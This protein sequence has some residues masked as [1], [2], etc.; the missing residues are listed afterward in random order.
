MAAPWRA[1]EPVPPHGDAQL[2]RLEAKQPPIAIIDAPPSGGPGRA[3]FEAF[4]AGRRG[5]G[6]TL[7]ATA[8]PALLGL[9]DRVLVLNAGAGVAMGAPTVAQPKQETAA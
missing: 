3:R 7:F 8:D 4:I 5:A 1:G 9:A 6:S 2:A